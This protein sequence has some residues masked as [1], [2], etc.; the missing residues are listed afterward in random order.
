MSSNGPYIN[1]FISRT[2]LSRRSWEVCQSGD[3]RYCSFRYWKP[4]LCLVFFLSSLHD[5][6]DDH[7]FLT[8]YCRSKKK[9]IVH[10]FKTEAS[11]IVKQIKLFCLEVNNLRQCIIVA[12]S[13][14]TVVNIYQ[15][16]SQMYVDA[17]LWVIIH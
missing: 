16:R 1:C 3:L 7:L 17:V 8:F 10:R 13:Y 9:K 12:K 15:W 14:L 5:W 6:W 11:K 4:V 2:P